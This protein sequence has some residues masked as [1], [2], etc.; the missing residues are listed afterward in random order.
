ML[1]RYRK[2]NFSKCLCDWLDFSRGF[3]AQ[4]KHMESWSE[5]LN[6]PDTWNRNYP[7]ALFLVAWP[8]LGKKEV[9]LRPWLTETLSLARS[10]AFEK[11]KENRFHFSCMP[12]PTIASLALFMHLFLETGVG[13]KGKRERSLSFASWTAASSKRIGVWMRGKLEQQSC[14]V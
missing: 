8:R 3:F 13:V 6:L 14:V 5:F 1:A 4:S 9:S 7:V 2:G 12:D 10:M 11:E